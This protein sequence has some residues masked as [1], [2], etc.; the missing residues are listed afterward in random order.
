MDFPGRRPARD[1]QE[2][3]SV[4]VGEIRGCVRQ[5]K[6]ESGEK[7]TRVRVAGRLDGSRRHRGGSRGRRDTGRCART[8]TEYPPAVRR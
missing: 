2:G 7:Q 8:A 6:D 4:T 5:R 3:Y 1:G